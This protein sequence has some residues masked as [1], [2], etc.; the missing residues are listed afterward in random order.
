GRVDV[1]ASRHVGAMREGTAARLVRNTLA[2][3]AA[4]VVGVV[5]GLVLTPV[6][7]TQLGAEA[8]GVYTLG[9]TFSF[10]GG[11]AA[12]TDLGIEAATARFVAEARV[13]RDNDL[14]NRL[15]STTLAFFG[16]LALALAPLL[17][18]LSF[19]FVEIFD[20]PTDLRGQA[21]LCFA[22]TGAQLLF[23]MPAR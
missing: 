15:A 18:G 16:S 5:V 17:A 21:I 13:H 14:V 8:Y 2:N 1:R 9:L 12:L 7:I 6:M 20:V 22:L 11:Y 23:E 4:G 10:L 3:G 19:V